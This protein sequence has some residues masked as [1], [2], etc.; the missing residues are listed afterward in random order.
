MFMKFRQFKWLTSC[1]PL[2]SDHAN[3]EGQ[4]HSQNR[5]AQ[6]PCFVS[7]TFVTYQS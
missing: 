4:Y 7:S 6:A 1:K 3:V 5:I 2:I